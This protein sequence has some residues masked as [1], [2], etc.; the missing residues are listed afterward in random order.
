MQR[1]LITGASR[2]LGLEFTRQFAMRGD[3]VFAGYRSQAPAVDLLNLR[4]QFPDLVKPVVL[5]VISQESIDASYKMVKS[6]TDALDILINNA[7]AVDRG[8]TLA[9]MTFESSLDFFRINAVAPMLI[10]QR[11]LELLKKGVNVRVISISSDYASITLKSDGTL[12][13]YCASKAAQN[14]F[15]RA[16]SFELAPQGI[17]ALSIHPGWV[18]TAMGGWH[19]E[20]STEESVTG[21]MRII[22]RLTPEDAGRFYGWDGSECAW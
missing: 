11:Y 14:M 17:I 9:G 6:Q 7:G 18:R 2:G 16:L 10:V 4:D 20:L 3:Q 15:T 22:D 21:M 5:D 19:A 12:M 8:E 13:S 1:V